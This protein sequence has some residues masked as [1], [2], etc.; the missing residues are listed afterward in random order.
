VSNFEDPEKLTHY[1]PGTYR[2]EIPIIIIIKII[3]LV[4]SISIKKEY[5]QQH[6]CHERAPNAKPL[7][8]KQY[9]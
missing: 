6:T 1:S 9:I 4:N 8:T 5:E 2:V 7:K 3:M